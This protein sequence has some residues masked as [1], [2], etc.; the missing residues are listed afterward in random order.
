M[1]GRSMMILMLAG[2]SGLGA[3]VGVNKLMSKNQ[4]EV[5]QQEYV[6]ATRDLKTEEVLKA[7]ML[8]ID[9]KP[10]DS[11][12]PNVMTNIKDC[13]DRWVQIKILAGE[14]LVEGKL[15]PKGAPPGLVSQIPKGKRAFA[16]EVNEQTGVSGFIMPGHHVDIIQVRPNTGVRNGSES[17]TILQ[18]VLVLAAGQIFTRPEDKSMIVRTVTFAVNPDQ[19]ET[20]VA[21]RSKGPLSLALRG[22]D[23][24]EVVEKPKP[25]P[26]EIAKVEP[27]PAPVVAPPPPPPPQPV[28][29][30]PPPK[31][32]KKQRIVKI[33]HGIQN[34]AIETI[35]VGKR[36]FDGAGANDA[37][38]DGG[39][40]V[41]PPR[42]PG[43]GGSGSKE[44][45]GFD[46]DP[47]PPPAAP[48]IDHSP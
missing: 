37:E 23:D 42:S 5:P 33:F 16:I 38:S 9:K 3:M 48:A 40:A 25:Q 19:V 24:V 22:V 27:E 8:K 35:Q 47:A 45:P 13:E 4:V 28:E 26:V 18:N 44:T 14:P 36:E 31:P 46:G 2:L 32:V 17:E 7:S 11:L 6:V 41:V 10:K 30:T 20:L 12:P 15:A 43:R 1:N 34:E 21:A 39:L 29:P